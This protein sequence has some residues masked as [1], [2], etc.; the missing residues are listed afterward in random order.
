MLAERCGAGRRLAARFR[1]NIDATTAVELALIAPALFALL[2]GIFAIAQMYNE[3]ST[4]QSAVNTS[5]RMIAT[6]QGVTQAQLAS[7][8]Q[9]RLTALGFQSPAVT[10]ATVTVNGVQLGH[11]TAT[12]TDAYTIPF[13]STYN[14]TFTADAYVPVASVP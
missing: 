10:Y 14:M 12:I 9:G 2:F 8:V 4:L 3:Q 13:V 6:T 5:G 11:L 1:K 7:A